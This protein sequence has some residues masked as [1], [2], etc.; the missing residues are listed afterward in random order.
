MTVLY[1]LYVT[2][3]N[4]ISVKQD[5]KTANTVEGSCVYRV[6]EGAISGV[7]LPDCVFE[8]GLGDVQGL[9]FEIP[10]RTRRERQASRP[11]GDSPD[12]IYNAIMTPRR[13]LEDFE[14]RRQSDAGSF[15]SSI[16]WVG[17]KSPIHRLRI[18]SD[19]SA[20]SVAEMV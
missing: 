19:P 18:F 3:S 14:T 17:V 13:L 5:Q 12:A 8:N 2:L 11:R 7:W 20:G 4:K 10:S 16:L 9:D 6:T 15:F 1:P